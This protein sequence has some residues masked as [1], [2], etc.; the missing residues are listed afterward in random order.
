MC[1]RSNFMSYT[2]DTLVMIMTQKAEKWCFVVINA[3]KVF[4]I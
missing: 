1:V 4:Q 2:K 3:K